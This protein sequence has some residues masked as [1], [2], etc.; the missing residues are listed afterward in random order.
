MVKPLVELLLKVENPVKV[1]AWGFKFPKVLFAMVTP[2]SVA[3]LEAVTEFKVT[4]PLEVICK[5]IPLLLLKVFTP[6]NFTAIGRATLP[7]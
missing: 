1:T 2:P 7:L 6:L 3:E 5:P 4:A